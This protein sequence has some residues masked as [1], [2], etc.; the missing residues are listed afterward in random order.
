MDWFDR[1][2]E[3]LFGESVRRSG[4]LHHGPLERS[5]SFL[6]RHQQWK[7][8]EERRALL[9][10]YR[11]LLDQER[12]SAD[13]ALHVF[14]TTQATG[15]QITRPKHAAADVLNHLLE[16][17]KDRTLEEGYGLHLSDH[18]ISEEGEHRERYYLKPSIRSSGSRPPLPQRFG[19]VLL[20]C[21]GDQEGRAMNLKVLITVY[22]DRLYMPAESGMALI[23]SLLSE[24]GRAFS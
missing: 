12:R 2:K 8:S 18:R 19:N 20:E 6:Q 16:E 1:L 9:A 21:W 22:S 17:F 15:I 24:R 4:Q 13:T 10:H 14:S 7:A 5:G 23:S 3:E 11:E